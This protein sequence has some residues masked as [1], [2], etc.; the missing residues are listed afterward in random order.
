M[1]DPIPA[2]HLAWSGARFCT[3]LPIISPALSDSGEFREK[4][5]G[6]EG[7]GGREGEVA[8]FQPFS[9]MRVFPPAHSTKQSGW[10]FLGHVADPT[11][12][13]NMLP[14]CCFL[15]LLVVILPADGQTGGRD[16]I[17]VMFTPTICKVRCSQDRCVNHCE[18]GNATTVFSSGE[19]G[20]GVRDGSHG[21]G[22]RVCKFF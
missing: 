22:F 11:A 15:S 16:R 10:E 8:L 13:L 1:M 7:R 5:P 18:R 20:A 2:K 12:A 6:W 19:G 21:P 17:R 14:L 9:C 3:L 4:R